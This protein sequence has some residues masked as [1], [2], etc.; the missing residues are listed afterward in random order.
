MAIKDI[1]GVTSKAMTPQTRVNGF[2]LFK[3]RMYT[4]G[5]FVIGYRGR[6]KVMHAYIV[7]YVNAVCAFPW[8][9]IL[10]S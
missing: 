3:V 2:L 8:M 9:E 7:C 10:A 4:Q 5:S 1:T 6:H